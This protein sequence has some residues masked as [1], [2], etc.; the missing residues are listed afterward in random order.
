ALEFQDFF[1]QV[2]F[3]LLALAVCLFSFKFSFQD[4]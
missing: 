2:N 3:L 4:P 1:L